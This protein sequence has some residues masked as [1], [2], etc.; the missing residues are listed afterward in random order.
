MGPKGTE[1]LQNFGQTGG[2]LPFFGS[3]KDPID[4]WKKGPWLV[5]LY[6]GWNTIQLYRDYFINHYKDPNLIN[7]DSMERQEF[8]FFSW[9]NWLVPVAIEGW[10]VV[11]WF[12]SIWLVLS[13]GTWKTDMKVTWLPGLRKNVWNFGEEILKSKLIRQMDVLLLEFILIEGTSVYQHLPKGVVWT[14]RDGV[15]GTPYHPFSTPW[16]I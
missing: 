3:F 14:L 10:T 11:S 4:Q 7:Q 1:L 2:L 6:E 5:G 12:G 8:F 15:I 16:K 13:N 9:L